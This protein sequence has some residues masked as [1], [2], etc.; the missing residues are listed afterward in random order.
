MRQHIV[1]NFHTIPNNPIVRVLEY[2]RLR[3]IVNGDDCVGPRDAAHVLN[4]TRDT[5]C[6]VQF[7]AY[8]F[9]CLAYLVWQFNPAFFNEWTGSTYNPTDS[10]VEF[11]EFIKV[12]L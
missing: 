9:T 6:Q 1:E 3:I 5:K 12:F 8:S 7:R 4:G 11:L 10:I 2:F